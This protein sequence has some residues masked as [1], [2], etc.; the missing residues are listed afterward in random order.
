MIEMMGVSLHYRAHIL[1]H[2]GYIGD[3]SGIFAIALKFVEM[4]LLQDFY[5]DS[6]I[7]LFRFFY[8]L[9]KR[10]SVYA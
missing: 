4:N 5:G 3:A 1:V 2:E 6:I 8:T 7:E 9:K 10:I